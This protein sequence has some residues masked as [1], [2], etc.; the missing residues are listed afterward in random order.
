[1]RPLILLALPLALLACTETP[2]EPAP[3][4]GPPAQPPVL[5]GVRL[6]QPVR[7][8]GTEPFW[9]VEIT[10]QTLS[11]YGMETGPDT[12]AATGVN[13]G[14]VMQGTVATFS[15]VSEKD[16]VMEVLLTATDCS[17]GMSDRTYPLTAQ[18]TV[19]AAKLQ[20]CAAQTAAFERAGESGRVE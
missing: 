3:P 8:V 9:R 6:D 17:D 14:P 20:G 5:A 4:K 18:V 7:A 13:K 11:Y 2:N 10:P 1:M 19:G 12:P 16:E 15:T